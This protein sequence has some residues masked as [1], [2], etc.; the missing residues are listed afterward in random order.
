MAFQQVMAVNV[1]ACL[2]AVMISSEDYSL[3]IEVDGILD[4]GAI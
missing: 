3:E 2:T 4:V 1:S